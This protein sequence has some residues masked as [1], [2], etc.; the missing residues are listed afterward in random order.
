MNESNSNQIK[1]IVELLQFKQFHKVSCIMEEYGINVSQVQQQVSEDIL[2]GL[3][4]FQQHCKKLSQSNYSNP[5]TTLFQAGKL[6]EARSSIGGRHVDTEI[7]K[8]ISEGKFELTKFLIEY[9]NEVILDYECRNDEGDT[10]IGFRLSRCKQY[11][12]EIK[13]LLNKTEVTSSVVINTACEILDYLLTKYSS[14]IPNFIHNPDV[15]LLAHYFASKS[16]PECMAVL[17]QH[18]ININCTDIDNNTPLDVAIENLKYDTAKLLIQNGA[19]CSPVLIKQLPFEMAALLNT[20]QFFQKTNYFSDK[21]FIPDQVLA[22]SLKISKFV[23]NPTYDL[24]LK[25]Q[26][27]TDYNIRLAQ[28]RYEVKVNPKLLSIIEEPPTQSR[29]TRQ[30]SGTIFDEET[31]DNLELEMID[32]QSSNVTMELGGE[33]MEPLFKDYYE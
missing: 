22:D 29:K 28:I 7:R 23:Q 1:Y 9:E 12:A 33:I 11:L 25:L 3:K 26:S 14:Y 27:D 8:A 16:F 5:V 10:I 18:R 20:Y 24:W 15:S 21:T 32:S 19:I 6:E 17:I 2:T 4:I 31:D 30:S 13:N